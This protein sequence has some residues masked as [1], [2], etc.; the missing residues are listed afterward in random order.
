VTTIGDDDSPKNSDEG[1][2]STGTIRGGGSYIS[3]GY[4]ASHISTV[5]ADV[6]DISSGIG[7]QADSIKSG[8][9]T[10]SAGIGP[11]RAASSSILVNAGDSIILNN[12]HYQYLSVL[13]KSSGEAEIF[14]LSRVG[15]KCV[16]KLYY[17]NFKPS[18]EIL[19]KLVQL[20][21]EDIINVLD[22]GYYYDRFFELMDYAEG[23]TLDRYLPIK[24]TERIRQIVAETIKSFQYCHNQGIIHKDIKPQNMYFKNSDGTDLL[25]GDFG[26]SSILESGMSR[27][28]TSQSLT[29][30]YAAPEMYGIHGKVYVGREVDYYALGITLI[31][32]WEGKSPFEGLGIHAISNVTTCG[33]V[34]VPEDMPKNMQKL[35]KGLITLDYTKRW[36]Y[37]E[38]HRWL[39]GEDVPV[40]FHIREINYPPYQFGYLD[41]QNQVATTPE[42]LAALIKKYADRGKKQ[43]Y[44]N[45]IA[46]WVNL[47]NQGLSADI[48]SIVEDDY[49]K[50][51]DAG[52]QKAIYIL[53]PDE[54]FE[55]RNG[56]SCHTAEELGD[57]LEADAFHYMIELAKPSH[58]FYLFLEAHDDKKEADTFRN[59][60]TTFSTKKAFNTIILELHSREALKLDGVWYNVLEDLLNYPNKYSVINGMKD[61]E[62]KMSLWIEGLN[63]NTVKDQVI[64]WRNLNRHNETTLTYALEKGSPFHFPNGD[65]AFNKTEFEELFCQFIKTN[66]F[67]LKKISSLLSTHDDA[68][69]AYVS[70]DTYEAF[71]TIW[72]KQSD[73]FSFNEEANYWLYH[74]TDCGKKNYFDDV[75]I[76][77]CIS[78]ELDTKAALSLLAQYFERDIS[79]NFYT[80]NLMPV[81]KRAINDNAISKEE[82]K[83]YGNDDNLATCFMRWQF[84]PDL[85]FKFGKDIA[86][87]PKEL[88]ALI[89]RDQSSWA[90]GIDFLKNNWIKKW[91]EATGSM[92]DADA[93][94]KAISTNN[95]DNNLE[96]ILHI[97]DPNLPWPQPIATPSSVELGRVLNEKEVV[98]PVKIKN[99]GRGYLYGSISIGN[100]NNSISMIEYTTSSYRFIPSEIAGNLTFNVIAAP[101]KLPVWSRQ[102]E[103]ITARTN[104]GSL[105]IPVSYAV[106]VPMKKMVFKSLLCGMLAGSF[107]I[108]LPILFGFNISKLWITWSITVFIIGSLLYFAKKEAHQFHRPLITPISMFSCIVLFIVAVA[109]SYPAI[110]EYMKE[111][112]KTK[113]EKTT[114]KKLKTKVQRPAV[115]KVEKASGPEANETLALRVTNSTV[116]EGLDTNNKPMAGFK[117]IMTPPLTYYA[118]YTNARSN[119]DKVSVRIYSKGNNV[120]E[121]V[122]YTLKY[123]SG[124]YWCRI[125]YNFAN[126]LGFYEAR[127]VV[128]GGEKNTVYFNASAR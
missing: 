88:A 80:D 119:H 106:G 46:A 3:S 10:I 40:Y 69:E 113:P 51:Q 73:T 16:F 97:L 110:D 124:N 27:H 66:E 96:S 104:G 71:G 5:R 109:T 58:P 41:G 2:Q 86:S 22:Y 59:Y 107:L 126:R 72:Y 68:S 70:G 21:H 13:S 32:I 67:Q 38:V 44:S 100:T 29:V 90:L 123:S 114:Q 30:G 56:T 75:F 108:A 89:D 117:A 4:A 19:K 84:I 63:D 116:T 87:T 120:W 6:V 8:G 62:S 128:N 93:W 24:D 78:N 112:F 125:S 111:H 85:G 122:P 25:I 76:I 48:D 127:L 74:Y 28:L 105:K 50:D 26:I 12:V 36:G 55:A 64:K 95:W 52:L 34:H 14:L 1:S 45:K 33:K 57:A 31:H 37:D 20:N 101:N 60:F 17:P 83:K 79:I 94:D 102:K 42:E 53:N 82:L 91:L 118:E 7:R 35:V 54:G 61:T 92:K 47:F 115:G 23:G 11:S 77:K 9:P 99:S 43:L 39:K 121:S 18:D 15:K 98:T 103:M 65:V 81:I 49:P